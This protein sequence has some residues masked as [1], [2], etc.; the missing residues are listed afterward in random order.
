MQALP[1]L[2]GLLREAAT[3]STIADL[4]GW[5]QETTMPPAA[6]PFRAEE[7]AL[8]RTL[9]HRAATD[10]RL[11]ESIERCASDASLVADPLVAANLREIRRDYDRA[12][13]VPSDLVTDLTRTCALAVEAWREAREASAFERFEPWLA[14]IVELQRRRAA[15]LGWP[16]GGEAYDALI[17]DYEPGMTAAELERVFAGFGAELRPLVEGRAPSGGARA[18][19]RLP[20]D[21]QQAFGRLL[22]SRLGFDTRAG[23]LDVSTHPFSTG[24]GP[25]DTRIT[26]RKRDEGFLEAVGS[27]L[28]EAGHALYEQGLPKHARFGEPLAQ[29]ASLGIHESQSR[30]WENHVGRSK[31]FWEWA[32]TA[33]RP[34]A[35]EAL[36]GLS[37]ADVHDAVTAVRP[38]P[39]RVGADETTYNLHI[40]LRFDLERAL[41]RGD[42]APADL[43]GAWN[44]RVQRDLGVAVPD[45]RRGCL[46][47]I[48]W[49]S[50]AIGYFPTYALGNLYAAQLWEAARAVLP[51]LDAQLAQGEFGALLDWLRRNVHAHGRRWPASE[52]CCRATGRALDHGPLVRHLRR[53]SRPAT[54]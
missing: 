11:G 45:D 21:A 51:D 6:A 23:R 17:E 18:D 41:I 49:A 46:Q 32:L 34:L 7:L 54:R 8:L 26:I 27:T 19:V 5:D 16:S 42:L 35:G 53:R 12:R 14:R 13:R 40:A 30:L 31:P 38:G 47:D 39:I 22:L 1:E 2:L 9:A 48:H 29:P 15:C 37:A 10:P 25:G 33:A 3:L 20:G 36:A 28:H 4:L 44:D 24:L 52:L 43:P 50:G